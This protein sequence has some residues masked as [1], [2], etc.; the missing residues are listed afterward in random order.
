[1]SS[2]CPLYT[3]N[4]GAGRTP[5]HP[6]FVIPGS[7]EYRIDC[8]PDMEP[9]C[10]ADIRDLTAL[11]AGQGLG[12]HLSHILEHVRLDEAV[13]VLI[14]CHRLLAPEGVLYVQ[15]PNGTAAARMIL[16]DGTPMKVAFVAAAGPITALDMIYGQQEMVR[17][18][19]AM[20]HQ[21]L[22]T[23][24]LLRDVL[25]AAG[26]VDIETHIGEEDGYNLTAIAYP[27]HQPAVP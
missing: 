12:V 18:L 10:V 20:A 26:F 14:G 6:D 4:I 15:V 16:E 1:M 21:C 9:D 19:P 3:Y 5:L 23:E 17:R 13:P 24:R 27:V 2:D 11:P 7:T 22:Y 8:D 25:L